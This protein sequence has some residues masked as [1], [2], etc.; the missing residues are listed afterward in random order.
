MLSLVSD[1]HVKKSL[2]SSMQVQYSI[3]T[4]SHFKHSLSKIKPSC[5]HTTK[6]LVSLA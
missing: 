3:F 2:L 4:Y 1:R 6:L 5:S